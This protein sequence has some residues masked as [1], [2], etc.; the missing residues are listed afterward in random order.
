M[1]KKKKVAETAP[2]E[3]QIKHHA[4]F[5][6]GD[7]AIGVTVFDDLDVKVTLFDKAGGT[8]SRTVSMKGE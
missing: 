4:F 5:R 6:F 7:E 2:K 3:P 1:P 8:I